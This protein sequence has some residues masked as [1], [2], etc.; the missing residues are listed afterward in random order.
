MPTGFFLLK[1]GWYRIK[2]K[3]VTALAL[4][5]AADGSVFLIPLSFLQDKFIRYLTVISRGSARPTR[6]M[7]GLKVSPR[8]DVKN[9]IDARY[10][11]WQRLRTEREGRIC[12]MCLQYRPCEQRYYFNSIVSH[13]RRTNILGTHF[14]LNLFSWQFTIIIFLLVGS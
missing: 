8:C 9:V 13:I 10:M 12:G 3:E 2:E 11:S 14:L 4:L 7:R 6:Q 1:S 5:I